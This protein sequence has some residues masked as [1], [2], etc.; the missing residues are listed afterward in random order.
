VAITCFVIHTGTKAGNAESMSSFPRPQQTRPPLS[1]PVKI[2]SRTASSTPAQPESPEPAAEGPTPDVPDTLLLCI[3]MQ[4]TF[5][6]MIPDGQRVQARCA[7]AL[8]AARGLGLP[9]LF[10]EQVPEKLGGTVE[11]L[12]ALCEKPEPMGK[13][14]FSIFGN[15]KIAAVL[16]A[17]G[18][19]QLLIVG[20]ETPVCIYQTVRDALKL[21]YQVTLLSDCIGARRPEDATSVLAQLRH[22][23]CTV[24]PAESVFYARLQNA[25]HDFFRGYTQ[26][27]KKYG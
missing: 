16:K 8:E 3:D 10:T 1:L 24:L 11:D 7:F 13:D 6:A 14:S 21:G 19:K 18:V 9:V 12:L 15:E 5:L 20:I 23:G 27:V 4:P 17:S 2:P 26:L 25:R 22:A